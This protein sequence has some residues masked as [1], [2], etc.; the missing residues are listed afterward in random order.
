M[1]TDHMLCVA[2]IEFP[3]NIV[4]TYKIP[5]LCNGSTATTCNR[6]DNTL[7]M[8]SSTLAATNAGIAKSTDKKACGPKHK[9]NMKYWA[10]ILAA[11]E[12]ST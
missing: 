12:Y 11:P 6:Y 4:A 2:S 8:I 1:L 10:L 7:W 3:L 9:K 5:R